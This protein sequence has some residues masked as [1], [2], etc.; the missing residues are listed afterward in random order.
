MS[1]SQP[2][3]R[4]RGLRA[5]QPCRALA[6]SRK[7]PRVQRQKTRGLPWPRH[8]S[9]RPSLHRALNAPCARSWAGHDVSHPGVA[10]HQRGKTCSLASA[11]TASK[12]EGTPL[13]PCD[14]PLPCLHG[15]GFSQLTSDLG[16]SV[17]RKLWEESPGNRG[18]AEGSLE[19]MTLRPMGQVFDTP[20]S[21][22]PPL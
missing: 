20:E 13:Q 15:P 8:Q 7:E 19:G 10:L 17:S 9:V 3:P 4:L 14:R 1:E 21:L 2:S 22:F 11:K 12:H 16:S 6:G 18:A 5:A